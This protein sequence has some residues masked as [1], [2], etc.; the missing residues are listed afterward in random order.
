MHTLSKAG[1]DTWAVGYWRPLPDI[2]GNPSS[3]WE[4]VRLFPNEALAATYV[5]FLNGG[6]AMQTGSDVAALFK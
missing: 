2:N 5:N 3:E 6:N 4:T 1:P